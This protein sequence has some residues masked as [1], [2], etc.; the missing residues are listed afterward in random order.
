MSFFQGQQSSLSSSISKLIQNPKSPEMRDQLRSQKG[1]E[2]Y[3]Q[4]LSWI[5]QADSD[6]EGRIRFLIFGRVEK[7]TSSKFEVILEKKFRSGDSDGLRIV[8]E[9]ESE[10]KL[11]DQIHS[12]KDFGSFLKESYNSYRKLFEKSGESCQSQS[13]EPPET[14]I[15]PSLLTKSYTTSPY[16]NLFYKGERATY[17]SDKTLSPEKEFEFGSPHSSLRKKTRIFLE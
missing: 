9:D 14:P 10:K 13:S 17:D 3:F 8:S 16:D 12:A 7:P 2:S 6:L 15:I 5:H 4:T 1:M 11:I